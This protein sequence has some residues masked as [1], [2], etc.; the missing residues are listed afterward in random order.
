MIP[1]IDPSLIF[2]EQSETAANP[3]KYLDRFSICKYSV[4][5]PW[6]FIYLI[7]YVYY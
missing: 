2:K 5:D 3:P 6:N 7:F 1:V 4:L